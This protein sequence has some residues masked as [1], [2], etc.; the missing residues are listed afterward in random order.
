[1]SAKFKD[2]QLWLRGLFAAMIGGASGAG[3]SW[4]GMAAA[5]YAGVDV[6]TL[7]LKALGIILASSGLVSLFAYLQKSP[8]PEVITED[9]VIVS[10]VA[11]SGKPDVV[12]TTEK[13]VTTK[14]GDTLT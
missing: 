7:N 11:Q 8:L 2:W 10:R 5:Q 13:T 3:A 6:P 9:T 1:M 12:T 14:E 4:L